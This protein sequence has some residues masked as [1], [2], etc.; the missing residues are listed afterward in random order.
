[1]DS[2]R[3]SYVTL[4]RSVTKSI[5]ELEKLTRKENLSIKSYTLIE[6]EIYRLKQAQIIAEEK[7]ISQSE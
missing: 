6:N 3:D 1:M 2:F 5:E 4:F 7:F